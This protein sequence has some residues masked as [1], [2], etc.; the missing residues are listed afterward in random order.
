MFLG[1][2]PC[3]PSMAQGRQ[4]SLLNWNSGGTNLVCTLTD[5]PEYL[6]EGALL[7]KRNE[8]IDGTASLGPTILSHVDEDHAPIGLAQFTNTLMSIWASAAYQCFLAFGWTGTHFEKILFHCTK[9]SYEVATD[10]HGN[11]AYL[12][13]DYAIQSN[14]PWHPIRTTIYLWKNSQLHTV[15]CSWKNRYSVLA[16]VLSPNPRFNTDRLRRPR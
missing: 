4:I 14:K 12:I 3:V 7:C 8:A 5:G 10:G 13:T 15:K 11:T 16:T 2:L 6:M 9:G 1:L